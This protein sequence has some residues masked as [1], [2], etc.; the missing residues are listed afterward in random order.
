MTETDFT[1]RFVFTDTDVRGELV[2]LEHSY[3]H[4]LAKH[5]YPEPVAA[6]LGELMAAAALLVS[7]IK[8]D[9]L[10]TL[11]ARS[12]GPLSL[13]MV[14]CSSQRDIRAIARYD[15]GAIS[16]Q[17]SL[18]ELMP[19]GV[20]AITVDPDIG[21]RY[22]GLVSLSGENL[23]A[24]LEEYFA[25]SEQLPS[26]FTLFADGRRARGL[27]LQQLPATT[28]QQQEKRA[29]DWQHLTVLA[30]TLQAEELL[31]LD[32]QVVLHRLYHEEN[33]ELF[34]AL[35]LQFK[36]SC[37]RERSEKALISLGQED[38]QALLAEQNN[39]IEIDCQFCNQKYLFDAQDV[40]NLFEGKSEN[41]TS[42]TV[43]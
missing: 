15:V 21:Q 30:R 38:V 3:A 26:H 25:S 43:H 7:T 35:T 31:G 22:Q 2:C 14:E 5:S 28:E 1:Q 10:L 37:S 27:L 33:I 18:N 16:A 17:A 20:L 41:S 39:S 34:A 9:G 19:S 11:Q 42:S 32:N 24:C 4:V 6:L 40:T 29:D 12:D 13:L 23:A 8:F 36:C